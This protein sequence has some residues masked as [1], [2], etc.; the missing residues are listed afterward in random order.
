MNPRLAMFWGVIQSAVN[1]RK[2]T[3]E[4]W[5]AVKSEAEKQGV[6]LAGVRI[7]DMNTLRGLAAR[8]RNASENF[9]RA[10]LD[11][12]I[13]PTMVSHYINSRDLNA[14]SQAPIYQV[15]FQHVVSEFGEEQTIW[16]TVR[17]TVDLPLTKGELLDELEAGAMQMAS[18]YGQEHLGIGQIE[19]ALV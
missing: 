12:V 4:V 10:D 9:M 13:D 14:I 6:S 15:R 2:S 19:I 7:Q 1:Q 16:R 5:Q 11:A 18:E 8:V 3:A 17:Y